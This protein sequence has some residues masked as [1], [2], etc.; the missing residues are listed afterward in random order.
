MKIWL[1]NIPYKIVNAYVVY[2]GTRKPEFIDASEEP[3]DLERMQD[4][5]GADALE[6]DV[7]KVAGQMYYLV[8]CDSMGRLRDRTPTALNDDKEAAFVG[9]IIVT[10]MCSGRI[11]DLGLKILQENTRIATMAG[12]FSEKDISDLENIYVLNKVS[13]VSDQNEIRKARERQSFPRKKEGKI[14]RRKR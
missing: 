8:I 1:E 14:W 13:V 7:V 5:I 11:S 3:L 4:I 10:Q 2:E 6:F 9:T 12:R